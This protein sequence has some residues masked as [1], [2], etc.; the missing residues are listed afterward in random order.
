MNERLRILEMVKE[1]KITPEE[2]ARLLDELDRAP[3]GPARLIRVRV[4]SPNGQKMQFSLPVTL[5]SSLVGLVPADARERLRQRG[6]DLDQVLRAVQEG[7][8]PGPVVDIRD[9]NGASV[10]V[11]VE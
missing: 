10:E 11:V 2:G 1:G 7:A 6:V 3:R 8:A 5:A 9:P 4:E